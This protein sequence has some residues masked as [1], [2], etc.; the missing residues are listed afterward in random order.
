M[1]G[2][3]FLA[4]RISRRISV[5]EFPQ[6]LDSP[7]LS[8]LL[9]PRHIVVCSFLGEDSL[10]S[11]QWLIIPLRA[12]H[13]KHHPPVTIIDAA[14][15][16]PVFMQT[17]SAFNDVVRAERDAWMADM[18]CRGWGCSE[19]NRELFSSCMRPEWQYYIQGSPLIYSELQRAGAK[20]AAAV[21]VLG[22]RTSSSETLASSVGESDA[23]LDS[24]IV[25]AEA[26][27]TTMLVELKMDFARIFTITEL[28]DESNS[29]FMGM[30]FE[31]RSLSAPST[32]LSAG[33]AASASDGDPDGFWHYILRH[34]APQHKS[35]KAVFGIPLYMS[36][37]L[38][39][40]E[41]C[42]NMVVQVRL[43]SAL[44]ISLSFSWLRL[45]S[46][47]LLP[48]DVL[49]PVDPQDHPS[50]GRWSAL[51]RRHLHVCSAA[52]PPRT[53]GSPLFPLWLQLW[54]SFCSRPLSS[55]L[56]LFRSPVWLCFQSGCSYGDLFGSFAS[57]AF[58][59]TCLGIYRHS[60]QSLG[61]GH[62]VALPIVITTPHSDFAVVA[63]D[64]VFVLVGVH[65]LA[66]AVTRLQ[67][68]Y[69]RRRRARTDR[70][71]RVA[72]SRASI[73]RYLGLSSSLDAPSHALAP[74]SGALYYARDS[75]S[76]A[77]SF[78]Y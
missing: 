27:F 13:A 32:S 67:A 61:A 58:S 69:R 31:A 43:L 66:R 14:E 60:T 73:S 38:L 62:H 52:P 26:I 49:Q 15:P 56:P 77:S 33:E 3:D 71:G 4:H 63:D 45:T 25:D 68:F 76:S 28:A 50:I 22:K 59:G 42:E 48:P 65:T 53:S 51:H 7:S 70:T 34:D 64:R 46:S 18:S 10:A 54:G 35:E 2:L 12:V 16:S 41:L 30:S 1:A 37:R 20:A 23:D 17:L 36:G 57:G 9:D 39:H 74:G 55:S 75:P 29:K 6:V 72:F 8:V 19:A 24:S 5:S 44:D 21:I 11:L 47:Y 40:P 78:V